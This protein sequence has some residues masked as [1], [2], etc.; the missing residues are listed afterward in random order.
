[1]K[2]AQLLS[3]NLRLINYLYMK[4]ITRKL[5]AIN[6]DHHFEVLLI[7]SAQNEPVTQNK[8]ARLLHIN[9]SRVAN[10]VFEL[11]E[12]KLI[13]VQTNPADRRQHY[14][15]LSADALRFIPYIE[16]NVQAVNELT[17]KGISEEKLNIFFEVAETMAQNLEKEKGKQE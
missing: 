9:K 10:I 8:L 2:N 17:N 16:T 6:A 1:M 12:K 7:L 5:S 14:V 3:Q 4:N 15:S 11:E 13:N